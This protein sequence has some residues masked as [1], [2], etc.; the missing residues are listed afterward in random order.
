[1][2]PAVRVFVCDEVSEEKERQPASWCWSKLPSGVSFGLGRVAGQGILE[3]VAE[4]KTGG[5]PWDS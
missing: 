3:C 5:Q 1:M 2:T 4:A